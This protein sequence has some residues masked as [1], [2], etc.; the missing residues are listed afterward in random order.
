MSESITVSMLNKHTRFLIERDEVLSQV[1]V[2]G[3]ISGF[4]LHHKTGHIYFSLK[5]SEASVKAVMFCQYAADLRFLPKEGMYVVVNC[6]VSFYER[7]GQFQLYVYDIM[8]KGRGAI[9]Q[10]MEEAK[11]RLAADGLF[12]QT[13][14]R[15]LPRDA[16]NIGVITSAGSAA[17]QDI[18]SVIERKNPTVKVTVYSTNV[19]GVAAVENIIK[20]VIGVNRSSTIDL[21]IIAR[22]GGSKEDLWYF[23]NEELVR[24][25][26]LLKM[27]F[28]SAVGH[29]TDTTLI[30]FV[31]D[32]RAATPSVAAEMAVYDV[33]ETLERCT[34]AYKRSGAVLK[35]S[36]QACEDRVKE[37][38]RDLISA[39]NSCFASKQQRADKLESVCRALDPKNVLIRGYARAYKDGTGIVSVGQIKSGDRIL[40]EFADGSA[41]C[42][43][44]NTQQSREKSDE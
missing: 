26:A 15:P 28:I 41:D 29:E 42:T 13:R 31:S 6:K 38:K 34:A 7:D 27:P 8:P 24:A 36:L 32:A 23:N 39:V 20:A 21:V 11:A 16:R 33:V 30:D 10:Q 25:A 14:K 1:W 2:E 12:S 19:Q 4:S 18:L 37:Q 40:L 22:G 5:D 35:S 9:Q 3:E 43:I 17:L 44:N